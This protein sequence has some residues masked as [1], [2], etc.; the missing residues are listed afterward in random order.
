[1]VNSEE[2]TFRL[3]NISYLRRWSKDALGNN[4]DKLVIEFDNINNV[5]FSL[6]DREIK[7]RDY[8]GIIGEC[9]EKIQLFLSEVSKELC[10]NLKAGYRN[11][12]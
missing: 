4:V 10:S 3:N 9:E 7:S 8:E 2:G 11:K 1:M 12:E 6:Y 5:C